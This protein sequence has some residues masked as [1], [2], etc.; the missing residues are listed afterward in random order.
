[1]QK[2]F[3]RELWERIRRECKSLVRFVIRTSYYVRIRGNQK[4]FYTSG[5]TLAAV[6]F[7]GAVIER[8]TW[9]VIWR[10]ISGSVAHRFSNV[11]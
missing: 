7:E 1:M 6:V 9:T 10:E 5:Y 8:R 2:K 4:Q 3:A 11:I